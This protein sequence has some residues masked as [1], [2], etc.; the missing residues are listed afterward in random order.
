MTYGVGII[1]SGWVAGEYVKIF[2]QHPK[3]ELV[4]IYNRTPKKATA[5]LASLGV[6]AIE[7]ETLD[8]LFDDDR[9]QIIA[10]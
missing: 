3:T 7:Y 2:A 4:G 10:S 9:V 8:E 6:E 1:G 5:L